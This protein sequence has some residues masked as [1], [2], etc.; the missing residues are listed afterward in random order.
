MGWRK[1]PPLNIDPEVIKQCQGGDERAFEVLYN[2]LKE[3]LFRWIFSLMRNHDDAE[4]VFQECVIRLFRHIGS[5][6]EPE[7]FSHWL[8]RIVVN[9]CNTHRARMGRNVH[10]TLEESIEVKPEDFVFKSAVP[11]NPRRSLMRKELM[12]FI[13]RNIAALP[14]KQR[15]A[16][17]LFDVEGLSIREVA[18]YL[19]CSEGAVKF[20]IHEGRKK[21]RITLSPLVKNIS[22]K[23]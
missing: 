6:R 7:R 4:E 8:Y 20:N 23:E 9:Q 5:L 12:D 14:P 15:M 17:I 19:G 11:E 2:S 18:E 16:V 13:N 1:L 3:N 10:V 21:L 22:L